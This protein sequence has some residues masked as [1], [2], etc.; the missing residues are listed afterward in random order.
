[1]RIA[2]LAFIVALSGLF[3]GCATITS[4]E[5]QALALSAQNEKGEPVEK[6]ACTLKND[7]GDW[8]AE[9]PSFVNVH[10]SAEDLIV[11]C[12]KDGYADGLLR[13]VS[14]AAGGM[15]GNIIF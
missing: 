9:A 8:K 12:K 10:R 3:G 11:E 14:R 6:V 15:F 5:N 13:A 7:K 4:S 1:M 2:I